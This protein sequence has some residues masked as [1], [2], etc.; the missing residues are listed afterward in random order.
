MFQLRH[1]FGVRR[2]KQADKVGAWKER[3]VVVDCEFGRIEAAIVQAI[4]VR[5]QRQVNVRVING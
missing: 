5:H 4:V 2:G 1:A 3:R